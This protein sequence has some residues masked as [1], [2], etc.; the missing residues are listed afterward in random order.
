MQ[1]PVY[2][3]D[4]N[5]KGARVSTLKAL[6][7]PEIM[8][9]E[10]RT[11]EFPWTE[12]IFKDCFRSGYAGL[13]LREDGLML[14]YG[15]ISYAAGEAHL[16]NVAV[17]PEFQGLGHGKHLTKRLIDLARWHHAEQ[18]F[19]E[20]RISNTRAQALYAALGFCEIGE[21]K[22]YYPG[23]GRREDAVVMALD[24]SLNFSLNSGAAINSTP[25]V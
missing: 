7:L 21:R 6:D 20:A 2:P 16:L 17:A 8:A 25:R 13:A 9:I 19:L 12:G 14:G 1:Q 22:N 11:Y 5:V 24:L 10:R 18:I 23:R 15:M 4:R 3:L